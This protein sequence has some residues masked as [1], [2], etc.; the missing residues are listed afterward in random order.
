MTTAE[1][2]IEQNLIAKLG[3]MT[4]LLLY[5]QNLADEREISRLNDYEEG[6]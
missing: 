6:R 3:L 2:Q 5:L 4:D 1:S